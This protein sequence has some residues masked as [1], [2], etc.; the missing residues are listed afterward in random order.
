MHR[1]FLK[2]CDGV[3]LIVYPCEYRGFNLKPGMLLFDADT[4]N[5]HITGLDVPF[6]AISEGNGF[7]PD[8]DNGRPNNEVI[9]GGFKFTD[10]GFVHDLIDI[11]SDTFKQPKI[12]NAVDL[13]LGEAKLYNLFLVDDGTRYTHEHIFSVYD[14]NTGFNSVYSHVR[15]NVFLQ[16]TGSDFRDKLITLNK[17]QVKAFNELSPYG[18][19]DYGDSKVNISVTGNVADKYSFHDFLISF[20]SKN[21][22]STFTEEDVADVVDG[23]RE[24]IK[25]SDYKDVLNSSDKA[26]EVVFD[27]AKDSIISSDGFNMKPFVMRVSPEF[28]KENLCIADF[29][30]GSYDYTPVDEFIVDDGLHNVYLT[31]INGFDAYD[32]DGRDSSNVV[33]NG[34]YF[35][36]YSFMP[37]GFAFFA[38]NKNVSS[39]MSDATYAFIQEAEYFKNYLSD[40][41][42]YTE[43]KE[44]IQAR[45]ENLTDLLYRDDSF[46]EA[47]YHAVESVYDAYLEKRRNALENPI[48]YE[49][50]TDK[51][52]HAVENNAIPDMPDVDDVKDL[53]EREF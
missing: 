23:L 29:T 47:E 27:V 14:P 24:T 51:E 45:F 25:V 20:Y 2:V 8:N 16:K 32:Y 37:T 50:L 26:H 41:D 49:K 9:L 21:F 3:N 4:D 31:S 10:T 15:G 33:Y 52:L 44:E 53:P 36:G 28:A 17:D 46:Y 11:R 1:K 35:N 5:R 7:V 12:L 13:A 18:I 39:T 22:G 34:F 19:V 42:D 6:V 48:T 43:L 40:I 38:F 30:Y